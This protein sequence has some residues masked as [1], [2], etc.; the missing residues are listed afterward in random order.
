M[1]SICTNNVVHIECV[2]HGMS[3]CTCNHVF[4]NWEH[5][6]MQNVQTTKIL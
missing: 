3:I 1:V 6:N 5:L 4:A 2:W